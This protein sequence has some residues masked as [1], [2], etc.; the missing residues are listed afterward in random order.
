MENHIFYL[1]VL[2]S[3]LDKKVSRE[4]AIHELNKAKN[5]GFI[6]VKVQVKTKRAKNLTNYK[7]VVEVIKI[8]NGPLLDPRQPK[9]LTKTMVM[10]HYDKMEKIGKS[11]IVKKPRNLWLDII[12]LPLTNYT[13]N[14]IS[15]LSYFGMFN[16]T[17]D[18]YIELELRM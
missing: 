12:G 7:E 6:S 5:A 8:L 1:A 10:A 15:V 11:T 13:I 16:D 2:W 18:E 3:N 14:L 17:T 9:G 4:Y